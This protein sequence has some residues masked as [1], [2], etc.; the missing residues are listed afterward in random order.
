M[1]VTLIFEGAGPLPIS[2]TFQSN[3][4]GPAMFFVSG[5]GYRN[6]W[7]GPITIQLRINGQ[8]AVA[9][10]VFA[11]EPQS[12]KALVAPLGSL[13]IGPGPTQFDIELDDPINCTA[14]GNDSFQASV[15]F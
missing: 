4:V 5:S 8:I 2:G 15:I 14:D 10:T 7:A 12:H 9:A 13:D 3:V 1:A 6:N 11:N